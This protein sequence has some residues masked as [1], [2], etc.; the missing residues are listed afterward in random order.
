MPKKRVSTSAMIFERYRDLFDDCAP[1][2]WPWL[3]VQIA[4]LLA[5][6]QVD[7]RERLVFATWWG[8]L[9]VY[10]IGDDPRKPKPWTVQQIWTHVRPLEQCEHLAFSTVRAGLFRRDHRGALTNLPCVAIAHN[11]GCQGFELRSMTET[12]QSVSDDLS[13]PLFAGIGK[14]YAP[15]GLDPP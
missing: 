4:L 7:Q 1:V 11:R 2:F 10:A 13:A 3:W 9:V 8:H 12:G 6:K 15:A 14:V 5:Q